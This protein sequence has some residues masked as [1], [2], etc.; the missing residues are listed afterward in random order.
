MAK[1]RAEVGSF[2]C[3]FGGALIVFGLPAV[4]VTALILAGYSGRG[5]EPI[6][7]SQVTIPSPSGEILATVSSYTV[8]QMLGFASYTDLKVTCAATSK[9][10]LRGYFFD[11]N[12]RWI[13]DDT[14]GVVIAGSEPPMSTPPPCGVRVILTLN[15]SL[16]LLVEKERLQK[17]EAGFLTE[18]RYSGPQSREGC[19]TIY[20]NWERVRALHA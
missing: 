3:L 17:Q 14:I 13:T 20:R 5:V 2:G 11:R 16:S 7:D 8:P 4:L 10:V 6:L 12:V 1:E 19:R 9:D 18:R 15:A